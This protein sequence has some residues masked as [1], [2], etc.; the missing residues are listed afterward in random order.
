MIKTLINVDLYS[1]K[2]HSTVF[3]VIYNYV[4]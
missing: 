2:L 4:I 1:K 3:S